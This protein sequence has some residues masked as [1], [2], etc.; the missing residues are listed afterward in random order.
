VTVLAAQRLLPEGPDKWT[1]DWRTYFFSER[2]AG[3]R[4]DIAMLLINEGTMAQYPYSVVDR[5]LLA[6]IVR[7]L[8]EAKARA[9]GLDFIFERPTE[10]KK[11]T[12]LIRAIRSSSL[13]IVVGAIDQRA[14]LSSAQS[15]DYQRD[16]FSEIGVGDAARVSAGHVFFSRRPDL[17]TTGDQVV[18]FVSR[19]LSTEP[20][21]DS[22]ARVLAEVD[23]R[24]PELKSDYIDWLLPPS[25]A[26]EIFATVRIPTHKPL[27]DFTDTSTILP[28]AMRPL[29]KDKIVLVGA[30]FIDRDLHLTPLSV[31]DKRPVSGITIHAQILAQLRDGRS[32]LELTLWQE[33]IV[34]FL[35]AGF[36]YFL[37][38]KAH[39]QRYATA[40]H[41]FSVAIIAL[42]GCLVFAYFKIV[43]PTTALLSG[44]LAG[45]I[46][47]HY[48]DWALRLLARRDLEGKIP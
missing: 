16:F 41:A 19:A 43:I 32:L 37:G 17:L 18:R 29:L 42:V 48:S 38:W 25:N 6:A 36:G 5:G 22:L 7:A 2:A 20:R 4:D 45:V 12:A 3:Q 24:K 28:S 35:L 46:G 15:L 39:L 40:T 9:I 14:R 11:D 31:A 34:V 1:N 27:T 10:P 47:G 13:P 30:E 23:G 44:W 21:V 8:G 26:Q 33:A